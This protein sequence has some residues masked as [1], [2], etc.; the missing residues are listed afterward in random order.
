MQI[1]NH[2][3]ESVLKKCIQH[4]M[5]LSNAKDLENKRSPVAAHVPQVFEIPK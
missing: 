1:L 4:C 3:A 5:T 2:E